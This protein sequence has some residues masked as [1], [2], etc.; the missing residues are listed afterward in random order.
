MNKTIGDY[1]AEMSEKKA[2][3]A[4]MIITNM[5]KKQGLQ[6]DAKHLE[7]AGFM[8]VIE[9]DGNV[10]RYKLGK[11]I[12]MHTLTETIVEKKDGSA[13]IMLD[14]DVKKEVLA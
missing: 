10:T 14:V 12:D 3:M 1:A 8:L 2:Q 4:D 9:R 11:I 5:L 6:H 7:S 13:S